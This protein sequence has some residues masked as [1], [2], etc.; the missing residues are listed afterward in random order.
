METAAGELK[1]PALKVTCRCVPSPSLK[2]L[3]SEARDFL[4][5]RDPLSG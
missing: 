5:E 4:C 3:D 1:I 2:V